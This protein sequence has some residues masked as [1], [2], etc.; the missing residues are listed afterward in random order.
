MAEEAADAGTDWVDYGG[1]FN[2]CDGA[3]AGRHCYTS[4]EIAA[5]DVMPLEE[6]AEDVRQ[7]FGATV[8][9]NVKTESADD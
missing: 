7:T 2:H 9:G 4:Q 1:W 3:A 8:G 5:S 6:D